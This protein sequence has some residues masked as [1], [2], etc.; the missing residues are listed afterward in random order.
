MTMPRP[1]YNPM[2]SQSARPPVRNNP[3]TG[4]PHVGPMNMPLT[5]GQKAASHPNHARVSAEQLSLM[6]KRLGRCGD[7]HPLSGHVCVTQPHDI[8]TEHMAVQIGGPMDGHVYATW[9]GQKPNDYQPHKG[10]NSG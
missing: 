2:P 8:D 9:G 4:K 6:A 1:P 7:I 3:M 5:G 10:K